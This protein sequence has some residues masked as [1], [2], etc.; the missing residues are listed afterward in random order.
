MKKA[1][2]YFGFLTSEI[3]MTLFLTDYSKEPMR[4]HAFNTLKLKKHDANIIYHCSAL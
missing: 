3:I 2:H 1:A 4:K